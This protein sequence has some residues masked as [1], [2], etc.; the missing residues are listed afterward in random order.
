MQVAGWSEEQPG[1]DVAEVWAPPFPDHVATRGLPL[2]EA[3]AVATISHFLIRAFKV[4]LNEVRMDTPRGER[5]SHPNGVTAVTFVLAFVFGR[6]QRA[7]PN[8]RT[9]AGNPTRSWR[10]DR[11]PSP[12]RMLNKLLSFIALHGDLVPW[13]WKDNGLDTLM[14]HAAQ[15]LAQGKL[16]KL[17]ALRLKTFPFH[18]RDAAGNPIPSLYPKGD[19]APTSTTSPKI[20][21]HAL[22]DALTRA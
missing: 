4:W 12:E 20:P 11:L 14:Q 21:S 9:K 16:D 22:F 15:Y 13:D 17:D 7:S 2:V 5:A 19:G 3:R 6:H 1:V 8:D 10:L 18:G